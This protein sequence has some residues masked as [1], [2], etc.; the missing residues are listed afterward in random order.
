MKPRYLEYSA[1][2]LAVLG[3]TNLRGQV[4]LTNPEPDIR[5]TNISPYSH[6]DS[7]YI[8]INTNG[9]D[10]VM[11]YYNYDFYY[12]E[13]DIHIFGDVIAIAADSSF[14][15]GFNYG[16][17][18]SDAL[19]WSSV[20][21]LRLYR[22][23]SVSW[24][25]G[26]DADATWI[27]GETTFIGLKLNIEDS[28]HYGWLRL[29]S[30]DIAVN[31]CY[32][33]PGVPIDIYEYA[34]SE[35]PD[36]PITCD[37]GNI[38]KNFNLKLVNMNDADSFNEFGFTRPYYSAYEDY[39]LRIFAI[40]NPANLISFNVAAALALSPDR[41]AEFSMGGGVEPYYIT[42]QLPETLLTI[43]GSTFDTFK[44][45]IFL[46]MVIPPPGDTSNLTLS[47]PSKW[48]TVS[49]SWCHIGGNITYHTYDAT[50]GLGGIEM[51][52]SD[53]DVKPSDI[54]Y[55]V[56]LSPDYEPYFDITDVIDTLSFIDVPATGADSYTIA[57]VGLEKD[58]YGDALIPG[59][60]YYGVVMS[61]ADT[62]Y[63]DIGCYYSDGSF[64]MPTNTQIENNS[65]VEFQITQ[66]GSKLV[67]NFETNLINYSNAFIEIFTYD[68]HKVGQYDI[69]SNSITIDCSLLASGLYL[70]KLNQNGKA[71]ATN[72]LFIE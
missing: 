55:R 53:D 71:F 25:S 51:T 22:F 70:I 6:D 72:K 26:C 34:V 35:I 20:E 17:L 31:D 33:G 52:F 8:D 36:A 43:A 27:G 47:S 16:A 48:T 1:S 58:I 56:A 2:A 3:T 50:L 67:L 65:E 19:D 39:T 68:G 7:V 62:Y 30:H 15:D 40:D 21:T 37:P 13:V 10:D 28:T 5:I 42:H 54:L 49:N 11:L 46:Y 64:V 12:D 57:L 69:T 45:Y 60:T 4:M 59:E 23:I 38:N 18:I 14:A 9:I 29:S 41:Y 24:W 63:F 61:P 44:D 32:V 66:S